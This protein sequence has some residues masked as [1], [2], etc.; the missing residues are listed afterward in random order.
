MTNIAVVGQK[1]PEI[2]LSYEHMKKYD[3]H[4]HETSGAAVDWT[5]QMLSVCYLGPYVRL[6]FLFVL[7]QALILQMA[8]SGS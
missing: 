7:K 8:F 1:L 4:K 5:D 3:G 2:D 6:F